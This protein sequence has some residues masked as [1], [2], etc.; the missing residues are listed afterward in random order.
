MVTA[1]SYKRGTLPKDIDDH[2]DKVLTRQYGGVKM[3]QGDNVREMLPGSIKVL[4]ENERVKPQAG[5]GRKRSRDPEDGEPELWSV[6]EDDA[7]LRKGGA[8]K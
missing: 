2:V 5:F 8:L 7:W 6:E 3:R 1:P 4:G